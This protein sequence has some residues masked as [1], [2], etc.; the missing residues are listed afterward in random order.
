MKKMRKSS[1]LKRVTASL[2]LGIT[3]STSVANLAYANYYSDTLGSVMALGSPLSNEGFEMEDW[4]EWEMVTFGIFLSNFVEPF[5][6]D[7]T[8]AFTAGTAKGSKGAGIKA[9]QFNAGGAYD[10]GG[11]LTQMLN[12]CKST[13]AKGGSTIK[14]KYNYYEYDHKMKFKNAQNEETDL[15]SRDAYLDD[16]FPKIYG[17]GDEASKLMDVHT[18]NIIERPLIAIYNNNRRAADN[19]G[20]GTHQI[21]LDSSG[22]S[23][24]FTTEEQYIP[25]YA[26][27]QSLLPQFYIGDNID[28]GTVLDFS[29]GYDLNIVAAMLSKVNNPDSALAKAGSEM[30]AIVSDNDD[31]ND[32]LG[33]K[34]KLYFDAFG[35]ICIFKDD[36]YIVVLPA[37][38]NRNLH[39]DKSPNLLNSLVVNGFMLGS[40]QDKM[41]TQSSSQVIS[42]EKGLWARGLDL[43]FAT[44]QGGLIGGVKKILKDYDLEATGAIG[45]PAVNVLSVNRD[46]NKSNVGKLIAY[47]DTDTYVV[48]A[49][50]KY[51][52]KETSSKKD[53][54]LAL[55]EEVGDGQ[56]N[57][58][59]LMISES[60]LGDLYYD[61][62]K[63]KLVDISKTGMNYGETL[64]EIMSDESLINANF[65]LEVTGTDTNQFR[66]IGRWIP[67]KD[68]KVVSKDVISEAQIGLSVVSNMFPYKLTD[69]ALTYMYTPTASKNHDENRQD[70]FKSDDFYYLTPAVSPLRGSTTFYKGY[71]NYLLKYAS[72]KIGGQEGDYITPES[73]RNDI[74]GCK[75]PITLLKRL[76]FDGNTPKFYPLVGNYAKARYEIKDEAKLKETLSGKKSDKLKEQLKSPKSAYSAIMTT[77]TDIEKAS[78]TMT[79][80]ICKVYVPSNFFAQIAN[81]FDL[82]P[83]TQFKAY[84]TNIYL[85]YLEYY[86]I[87][88]GEDNVKLDKNLFVNT[89]FLNLDPSDYVKTMSAEDKEKETKNNA[90]LLLS[91]TEAGREY[92]MTLFD[93]MVKDALAGGYK[94]IIDTTSDASGQSVGFLNVNSYKENVFTLWIFEHYNNIA[95]VLFGIMFIVAF[96]YGILSK[97]GFTWFIMMA[98]TMLL[99]LSAIPK[100]TEITPYICNKVI[101]KSFGSNT[102]Y[103]AAVED[104]NNIKAARKSETVIQNT[105]ANSDEEEEEKRIIATLRQQSV[106]QQ[107]KALLIKN[108][109]S[110]K[111]IEAIDE[112]FSYERLQ[113][114][115]STRWLLPSLMRQLSGDNGTTNYLYT[116]LN[117]LFFNMSQSYLMMNKDAGSIYRKPAVY[118][119][120][121]YDGTGTRTNDWKTNQMSSYINTESGESDAGATYKSITRV[122]GSTSDSHTGVYFLESNA[123]GL[124]SIAANGEITTEAWDKYSEEV[125]SLMGSKQSIVD[126]VHSS[127]VAKASNYNQNDD[128]IG[129]SFPYL[130]STEN[131]GVYMYCLVN[132]TFQENISNRSLESVAYNILQS[133]SVL[134][135]TTHADGTVTVAE[136]EEGTPIPAGET[137]VD[138]MI[139]KNFMYQGSTGYVRDFLDLEEVFTNMIP[140]LYQMQLTMGGSNGKNGML[141]DTKLGQNIGST[142]NPIAYSVY[143]DEDSSWLYRCNWVTKLMSDKNWTKPGKVRWKDA[144]GEVKEAKIPSLIDP[145]NYPT[146]RPM[147]FS[148]A[149][150]YDMG[151]DESYLNKLELRLLKIND[152]VSNQWT[153]LINY[154]NIDGITKETIYRLMAMEATMTF[155]KELTNKGFFDDTRQ[156]FPYSMDLRNISFDSLMRK[157]ITTSSKSASYSSITVMQSVVENSGAFVGIMVLLVAAITA[158]IVPFIRDIVLVALLGLT[159]VSVL[160]NVY[161][162]HQQKLKATGGWAITY[163]IFAVFTSL[164]YWIFALTIGTGTVDSIIESNS[165]MNFSIGSLP[166]KLILILCLDASYL[167]IIGRFI[168]K[169]LIKGNGL[170]FIKD[171]GFSF[172]YDLASSATGHMRNGF[173][174]MGTGFRQAMAYTGMGNPDSISKVE[175]VNKESNSVKTVVTDGSI[176]TIEGLKK[177]KEKGIQNQYDDSGYTVDEVVDRSTKEVTEAIN[178][179]IREGERN[180]K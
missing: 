120:T 2:L 83:S 72:G 18:S 128:A 85:T 102:I 6:D 82:D 178:S 54:T 67:F 179:R 22:E 100:Y 21:F 63:A 11:T 20:K 7:Y 52:D 98:C 131:I 44:A 164:F 149:Q 13:Q 35:N 64:K 143:A 110:K 95:L 109:I 73:T 62:D 50:M 106:I 14:V 8:S 93:G 55:T 61:E 152:E 27:T 133:V 37:A 145:R 28:K 86:G 174:S 153:E 51:L 176:S 77:G 84:T 126:A 116:T 34:Y 69:K 112:E 32:M 38:C 94:K 167:Y 114:L 124:P 10:S 81:V 12:Y 125:T 129:T 74:F 41:V 5:M 29:N 175:I 75:N 80:R 132:D 118:N 66:E 137:A 99:S 148:E 3:L 141:G 79:A 163:T 97:Q 165:A 70:L 16:L 60:N 46:I 1:I 173:N 136:V 59:G 19:S 166:I 169:V 115:Q 138:T 47:S 71:I 92:R 171:G 42:A 107:D 39:M 170:G 159:I 139:R 134:R 88:A 76:V 53:D 123:L 119:D 33:Q 117:D 15:G 156:L 23:S 180:I 177:N 56:G 111:V 58:T 9:L 121:G 91:P 89:D 96:V 24:W 65:K 122:S 147:I 160:L 155:N 31:I 43:T 40:S 30:Q 168:W 104:I 113:T 68:Y 108:D 154:V 105:T 130:W 146:E 26:P 17:M 103:W 150:M 78:G 48:P 161:N 45:L 158:W 172:F 144:N 151:L 140:Y 135:E 49:I 162:G 142:V 127:I 87:L 25:Y 36:R 4:N 90:F 101:Q 157:L 57:V